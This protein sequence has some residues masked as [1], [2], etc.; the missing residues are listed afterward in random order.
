MEASTHG[1]LKQRFGEENLRIASMGAIQKP[2]GSVR[3]VHDGTHGVHVNQSIPQHNLLS[4]PGPGELALLVRQ[5]QEQVETPF[6]LAGD[7]A[8]AHRLV[9]V[10]ERDWGL[11]ACRVEAGS[12]TVFVNRG[13]MVGRAMLN[14]FFFQLVFVDDLHAN[15]FGHRKY[16][17]ALIWLVLY[18]RA[19]TPFAWKK[20][21]GGARI[22]FIGYELD[23]TA[24]LVGLGKV[25][26]DW[27]VQWIKV[28]HLVQVIHMVIPC[29]ARYCQ[30][31]W[32]SPRC[33]A[34]D[35]DTA[36]EPLLN[37]Y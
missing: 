27:L 24:R 37:R 3:P 20:F 5:S 25:R 18:L 8:A 19:G 36:T 4:V 23:C 6:A 2:D 35:A 12:D 34:R 31:F 30:A 21:K 11:L 29:S 10:R 9:L 28:V 7:V 26:G 13:R 33:E 1:A 16:V 32:L 14:H 15:F 22:A 17:N